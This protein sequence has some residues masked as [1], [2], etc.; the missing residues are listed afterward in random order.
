[1]NYLLFGL[2][3]SIGFG[4]GKILTDILGEIIFSRL[5]K[6]DVYRVICKKNDIT[7]AEP[8]KKVPIGFH[9]NNMK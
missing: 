4:I 1:M 6:N 8:M 3:A 7:K 5:H 9:A 2:L